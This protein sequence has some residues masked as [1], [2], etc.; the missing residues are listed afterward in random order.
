MVVPVATHGARLP[1]GKIKKSKLRGQPSEG[2]LCSLHDLGL[3]EASQGLYVLSENAPIGEAFFKWAGLD[4]AVLDFEITPNRYDC[5]SALGMAREISAIYQS[6]WPTISEVKSQITASEL[7][8]EKCQLF[9]TTKLSNIQNKPLPLAIIARLKAAGIGLVHPVVDICNYVMID[10]GQPMHAYD[11]SKISGPLKVCVASADEKMTT[12]Q[13]E[14]FEVAKGDLIVCDD[15]GIRAVA[16]IIGDL[17]SS[18]SSQTSEIIIESAVFDAQHI[19]KTLNRTHFNTQSSTRFSRGIDHALTTKALET[20]ASLIQKH[21]GA[22]WDETISLSQNTLEAAPKISLDTPSVNDYLGTSLSQEQI[23]LY[24]ERLGFSCQLANSTIDVTV[25]SHR[26]LD[27]CDKNDLIE[28]IVRLYG[29]NKLPKQ[30]LTGQVIGKTSPKFTAQTRIRRAAKALKYN[31]II[32]YAFTSEKLNALFSQDSGR[33][34]RIANPL[35]SEYE[36]M[37]QN[38]LSSILTTASS[39]HAGGQNAI[40]LFEIGRTYEQDCE[41][42]RVCFLAS[43]D[44]TTHASSS[45]IDFYRFCEE[46]FAA[47]GL[48][49]VEFELT[50][51]THPGFHPGICANIMHGEKQIGVVG[52]LHPSLAVSHDFN[53]QV[54]IAEIDLIYSSQTTPFKPYSTLPI[55]TRDQSYFV[56]KKVNFRDI[57]KEIEKTKPKHLRDVQVFDIYQEANTGRSSLALRFVFRHNDRNLTDDEVSD[58]LM[59]INETLKSS[60]NVI[61]R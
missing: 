55:I 37:R 26:V 10:M 50:P 33:V 27:V 17:H 9:A 53:N 21:L 36:I 49:A 12:L 13:D 54:Y 56:D 30:V 6:A 14:A 43:G 4:G 31:E 60:L 59:K 24:L 40:R 44:E 61:A 52:A 35:S 23:I 19:R 3:E 16:G 25:P 38:M 2:M 46:I 41:N 8:H 57:I 28:E 47:S 7:S 20:A 39:H 48:N 18:V 42:D 58:S 45:T 11:A 32:T 34:V 5:F 15:D 29:F 1:G 51:A 22:N